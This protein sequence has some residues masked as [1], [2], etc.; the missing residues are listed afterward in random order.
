MRHISQV[1][2]SESGLKCGGWWDSQTCALTLLALPVGQENTLSLPMLLER[3]GKAH[4]TLKK[5]SIGEQAELPLPL[6]Q[7]SSH[8]SAEFGGGPN[9]LYRPGQGTQ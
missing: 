7:S 9:K 6:T 4:P 5:G 1:E 8:S 3:G 2:W